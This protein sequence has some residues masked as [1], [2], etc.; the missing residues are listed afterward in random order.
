MVI[1]TGSCLTF[2]EKNSTKESQITTSSNVGGEDNE[3]SKSV[4]RASVEITSLSYVPNAHIDAYL[5]F[6]N[7]F[8]IRESTQIKENG[9]VCGFMNCFLSEVLALSRAHVQ[10]L[11]GNALVSY[12]LNQCVLLN[13]PHRNQAQCLVNVSGDAVRVVKHV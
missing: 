11:G 7:I 3:E 1:V 5:G 4:E 2:S 13:N 10:S 12:R 6:I 8:L 9:G